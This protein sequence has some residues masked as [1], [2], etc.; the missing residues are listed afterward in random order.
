M[1]HFY[2]KIC[3]IFHLS[4]DLQHVTHYNLMLLEQTLEQL[5]IDTSVRIPYRLRKLNW[6]KPPCLFFTKI[7]LGLI[8]DRLSACLGSVFTLR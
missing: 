5:S 6:S 1:R 4:K 7:P 8:G 2:Y 3:T